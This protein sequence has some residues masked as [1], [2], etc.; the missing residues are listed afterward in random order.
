MLHVAQGLDGEF[1]SEGYVGEDG[2]GSGAVEDL[3]AAGEVEGG[4][5]A[6]V[7]DEEAGEGG[8]GEVAEGLVEAVAGVFGVDEG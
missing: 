7:G 1:N 8:G 3:G 2:G 6:E 4:A 5:G